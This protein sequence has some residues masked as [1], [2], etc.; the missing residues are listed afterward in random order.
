MLPPTWP[1]DSC[2]LNL[3]G[4]TAIQQNFVSIFIV[5]YGNHRVL[6]KCKT[7]VTPNIF[8]VYLFTKYYLRFDLILVIIRNAPV[9]SAQDSGNAFG[10]TNHSIVLFVI[11]I[12]DSR[13][14]QSHSKLISYPKHFLICI[15]LSLSSV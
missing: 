8:P 9:S 13:H 7:T 3:N 1:P 15:A 12:L 4:L 10:I 11:Q 14:S 6:I 2:P 5:F